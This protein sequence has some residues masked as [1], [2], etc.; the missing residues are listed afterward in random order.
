MGGSARQCDD[1]GSVGLCVGIVFFILYT[2]MGLLISIGWRLWRCFL[3][4]S[5]PQCNCMPDP[6]GTI[7]ILV[8]STCMGM[9]WAYGSPSLE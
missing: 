1:G 6:G 4:G 7:S 5:L 2:I 3:A 8:L 9:F